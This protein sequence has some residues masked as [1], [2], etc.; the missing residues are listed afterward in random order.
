VA[1]DG[2]TEGWV[3]V[4][5]KVALPPPP[6]RAAREIWLLHQGD[7]LLLRRGC[8][9]SSPSSWPI[10]SPSP[11]ARVRPLGHLHRRHHHVQVSSPCSSTALSRSHH[12]S[13]SSSTVRG[14]ACHGT[15]TVARSSSSWSTSKSGRSCRSTRQLRSQAAAAVA[16]VSS[17]TEVVISGSTRWLR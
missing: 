13:P 1:L 15:L 7:D 9:I 8:L 2:V 3:T 14:A 17:E 12:S 5:V 11:S 6:R 4:E 10:S 16:P